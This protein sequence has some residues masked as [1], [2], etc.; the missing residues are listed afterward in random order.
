MASTASPAPSAPLRE[1]PKNAEAYELIEE[2]GKG[3]S[4]T[5]RAPRKRPYASQV[6][7]PGHRPSEPALPATRSQ[8]ITLTDAKP[9]THRGYLCSAWPSRYISQGF[10]APISHC[11]CSSP[12][13]YMAWTAH[14]FATAI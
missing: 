7:D 5:V 14:T 10:Q 13:P 6:Y 11:Q 9:N 12:Q 4:A 8:P 3:V 1:Y 2:V